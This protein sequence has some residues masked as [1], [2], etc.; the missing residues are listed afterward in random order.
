M[1]K[2][3]YLLAPFLGLVIALPIVCLVL[4]FIA[5]NDFFMRNINAS[6]L[7]RY[8]YHT[9]FVLV[10]TAFLVLLLGIS[11][12]FM[13][14][15]FVYFGS[16]FFSLIF[17][18]PLAFPA[19]ILGYTY[20]GFFEFHGILATLLFQPKIKLDI[21]NIYGVT[22]I[23]SFAMFPYVFILARVSFA[24]LSST[25]VELV[26]LKQLFFF[27]AFF[28]V[29]LPLAYPAIFAGLVL[30]MMEVLSDYGTVAYF[31]VDTFSVGIFKSWFGYGNLGEAINLAMILLVVVFAMMFGEAR[32]RAKIRFI[33]ATHSSQK[34]PKVQLKGWHNA[35]AFGLSFLIGTVSLFIPTGV[36]LYWFYL[37]FNTLD[38]SAL[39]YLYHTL[40]LNVLSSLLIIALAFIMVYASRFYPSTLGTF[41]HKLSILGYSIPG[42]IVGIGILLFTNFIDQSVGK[43]ILGGSF[44]ALIFAYLSRYFAASIGS[45]ENG[46]SK[47]DKSI[48]D[49]T[50]VFGTSEWGRIFNVYVPLLRPYLL[51]GFLI[52]YIDLAKELP[53]TLLLRPFNYDTIAIR[54]YELASNEILYKSAFPSLLLVVTTAIAVLLLHSKFVRGSR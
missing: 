6:E 43:V 35:L 13:S 54:I 21:L 5:Q 30:A 17:V 51:S 9:S 52:L 50:T 34:A 20:V 27:K 14:A 26:S 19:Y 15:R 11:T 44:F 4:Y 46:F 39:G 10:G 25:V 1:Q 28:T 49:A 40:S 2:F 48:D 37:D 8:T 24:S 7:V 32:L 29:Y 31:G 12:A 45:V 22:A 18:L 38:W 16:R 42:A 3:K 41:S 33:S 47:I 53:A 36:L 23:L